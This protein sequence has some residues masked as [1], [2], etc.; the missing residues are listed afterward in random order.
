MSGADGLLEEVF[1]DFH[2]FPERLK[3]VA[4]ML[5]FLALNEELTDHSFHEML[6]VILAFWQ[7]RN[8]DRFRDAWD[9]KPPHQE[10]VVRSAQLDSFL[11]TLQATLHGMPPALPGAYTVLEE[12]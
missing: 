8:E 9:S 3:S 6:A 10:V 5:V 7:S 4:R 12:G 2:Q 11:K 1:E